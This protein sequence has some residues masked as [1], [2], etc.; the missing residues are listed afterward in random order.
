MNQKIAAAVEMLDRAKD[1]YRRQLQSV[2]DLLRGAVA[3]DPA[4][5]VEAEA[6]Q[7]QYADLPHSPVTLAALEQP[8]ADAEAVAQEA[9]VSGEGGTEAS[10]VA[11][12]GQTEPAVT[13]PATRT[14]RRGAVK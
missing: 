2:D 3:Q 10:Q 7:R 14:G 1:A 13:H 5:L 6:V 4:N 12:E 11:G 9:E 8:A